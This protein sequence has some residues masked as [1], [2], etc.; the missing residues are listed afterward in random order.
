MVF[1]IGIKIEDDMR[2]WFKWGWFVK[3]TNAMGRFCE[4]YG[5]IAMY[6]ILG[7]PLM[8]DTVPL[9]I[10]SLLNKDG[11]VFE[12]KWFV[13]TNFWAGVSRGLLVGIAAVGI[14]MGI[15]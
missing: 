13:I 1:H 7:I 15:W 3:L 14:S 5:Y 11:E 4:K 8:T 2:R 6:I 12:M 9:Y 10:F